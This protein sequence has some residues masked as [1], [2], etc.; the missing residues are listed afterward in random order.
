[1]WRPVNRPS[2]FKCWPNE[3]CEIFL[4]LFALLDARSFYANLSFASSFEKLI[5]TFRQNYTVEIL[6]D[7]SLKTRN[8][9]FFLTILK[10]C[11]SFADC[12][13]QSYFL[14]L[15]FT[16]RPCGSNIF[17]WLVLIDTTI[18]LWKLWRKK[19]LQYDLI[20]LYRLILWFCDLNFLIFISFPLNIFIT[21]QNELKTVIEHFSSDFRRYFNF[22][23]AAK[24]WNEL[25]QEAVTVFNIS[26]FE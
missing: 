21:R 25:P 24:I 17:I 20:L 5:L 22:S 7:G 1:M 4:H 26:N 19:R 9:A 13:C 16:K 14:V 2:F 18:F 10:C 8:S 12:C 3:I 15:G 6:P 23:N 11:L